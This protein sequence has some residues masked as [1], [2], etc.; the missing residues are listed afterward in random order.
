MLKKAGCEGRRSAEG[1]RR[2]YSLRRVTRTRPSIR[3]ILLWG[4]LALAVVV[5]VLNWTYGRLPITPHPTGRFLQLEG[6]KLR[7]L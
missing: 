7:Y 2:R 3:K 1:P 6:L 4:V 5:V